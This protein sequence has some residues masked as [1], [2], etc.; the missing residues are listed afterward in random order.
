MAASFSLISASSFSSVLTPLAAPF[1]N[2]IYSAGKEVIF[3]IDVTKIFLSQEVQAIFDKF[4]DSDTAELTREEFNQLRDVGLVRGS[5]GGV[6]D[7]FDGL[8][9]SGICKLSERGISL[10]AYQ[11]LKS[12]EWATLRKEAKE[13]RYIAIASLVVAIFAFFKEPIFQLF[14][15]L[16]EHL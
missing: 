12:S 13:T 11:R 16:L 6:S 15:R 10:K 1:P 9:A 7:F 14:A 8:P 2:V 5:L 3:T 4:K